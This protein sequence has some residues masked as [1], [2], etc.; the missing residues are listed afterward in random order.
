MIILWIL[1]TLQT[2]EKKEH[3]GDCIELILDNITTIPKSMTRGGTHQKEM[4]VIEVKQNE[5]NLGP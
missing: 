3:K 5:V 2:F 1:L 4:Y